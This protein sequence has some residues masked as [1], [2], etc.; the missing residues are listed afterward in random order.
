MIR[1][2][3]RALRVLRRFHERNVNTR[4]GSRRN[5][6][7]HYDLGNDFYSPLLDETL[8]YSAA[9][10]ERPD[11][12]LREAQ[13]AKLDR[14]CRTLDLR[15][16][17]HLLEIGTGWGS[18][19]LHAAE[20]YGC[21][22]TTTTIST[23]QREMAERRVRDAGLAD[24]VRVL[25]S[26]DRDLEGLYD[27][28]VSIEM[29]EAVG[30]RHYDAYFGALG[31]L[32]RPGGAACLQTILVSDDDHGEA[33][34]AVDFIQR[35]VFPGSCIPSLGVI[36]DCVARTSDLARVDLFDMTPHYAR[37]LRAWRQ[38]L[39][40]RAPEIRALGHD[41]AFLRLWEFYLAYCE[42]GFA[43]RS[44]GVAQVLL[45]KPGSPLAARPGDGAN[46]GIALGVPR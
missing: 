5:I 19:A 10:F 31:R 17:D 36:D 28:L 40:S 18:L 13:V 20:R 35:F 9:L 45:T 38:R 3:G 23:A 33:R 32:L 27:K 29:V 22:V 2:R 34:E 15:P 41:D 24:R 37:T 16:D 42:G 12:T 44:I 4:S 6:A 30:Y 39:L 11:A 14:I 8:T 43:E 7:A 21:R 25:G 26:D 1:Q 46:A